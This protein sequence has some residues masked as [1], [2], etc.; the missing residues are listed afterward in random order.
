M[1]M[2]AKT[3]IDYAAGIVPWFLLGVLVAYLV[4]RRFSPRGISALLGSLSP[5]RVLGALVLGM[6]SPLSIIS[7]LSVSGALVRLG[8]NPVLL[9]GFFAAERSYDFQSFPII[10][11]FF[12]PRFAVLNA[13]A[14]YVSLVVAL[15]AVARSPVS[16]RAGNGSDITD[17]FWFRQVRLFAVVVVGIAVAAAARTFIPEGAFSAAFRTD[18]GGLA[19][20]T[21]VGFVSYFGTIIGNYPVAK[22]FADLGMSD[23]GVFTFLTVSPLFNV[24][25]IALFASAARWRQVARFFAVYAATALLFSAGIGIFL[26]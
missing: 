21:A 2:F 24:V 5:G 17:G 11:G 23:I 4:E 3:F 12:G 25:I 14:I 10:A 18:L 13:A 16:F 26:L 15:L 20:G 9:L 7:Q 1:S 8:A 22:A 19:V 6:I